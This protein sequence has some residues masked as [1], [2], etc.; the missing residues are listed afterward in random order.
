M[1]T[2]PVDATIKGAG[3]RGQE[4]RGCHTTAAVLPPPLA[5]CGSPRE[6][7]RP[8]R[9]TRRQLPDARPLV[10]QDFRQL[11]R[12]RKRQR[13]LLLASGPPV[14][15]PSI[16]QIYLLVRGRAVIRDDYRHP[17]ALCQAKQPLIPACVS[18]TPPFALPGNISEPGQEFVG[19][20]SGIVFVGVMPIEI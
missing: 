11:S 4:A 13:W 6:R 16:V 14:V 19:E 2:F 20:R 12:G 1:R 18:V 15:R 17:A 5:N 10:P 9:T 8:P 7:R 3:R